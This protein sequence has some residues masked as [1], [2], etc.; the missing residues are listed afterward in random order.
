[1]KGEKQ[2]CIVENRSDLTSVTEDC[3]TFVVESALQEVPV[4]E[5]ERIFR[6]I[7][8]ADHS[9]VGNLPLYGVIRIHLALLF[10][11]TGTPPMALP[12]LI[13]LYR[14]IDEHLNQNG[15]DTI[16]C[17]GLSKNYQAVVVDVAEKHPVNVKKSA[18]SGGRR[19]VVGFIVGI[20]GYFRLIADQMFSFFWKHTC[21]NPDP[22]QTVF[23]P[24]V[25]RF[26]NIRPVLDKFSDEYE[27]VLP[28]SS[29]YWLRNRN[30]R[31]AAIKK[32]NPSPLDY[33]V[34]LGGIIDTIRR[35]KY[36]LGN[37]FAEHIP[38]LANT[39]VAKQ[40]IADL[41][42]ERLVVGSLGSRQQSILYA[43]IE[44]G[45][46][47]YHVP[48]SGTNGYEK[49]PPS[50]TVHF[51]P[52]HHIITHLEDSEQV[53]NTENIVPA[54][55]PKLSELSDRDI[56]PAD[57]WQPDAIRI[58]IATQPFPDPIRTRFI[59]QV[60]DSLK[61]TPNSIDVVVKIHPNETRTFYESVILEYP[62]RVRIVEKD[63]YEYVTGA[64]LTITINS[65][66]GLESMVVGTPCVCIGIWSPLIRAR[67]YAVCGPTPVLSTTDEIRTF[68]SGLT[69]ARVEEL[70]QSERTFANEMYLNGDIADRISDVILSNNQYPIKNLE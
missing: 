22:T 61:L 67:P 27:L 43:A 18:S 38:G 69:P 34:T 4:V 53:S 9:Q 8:E 49:T 46:D 12:H 40:M 70:A 31:Y 44:A 52:G 26:N 19:M 68:F 42:P 55:R 5:F 58:V 14:L 48:H 29:V 32:Y 66:V 21:R 24:H 57:D 51:V 64:E 7:I 56:K 10:D 62:F 15:Y 54:G 28:I 33:F 60:L 63:I 50:E 39:V 41:E 17:H 11:P 36:L 16:L 59:Q 45:I 25:N 13:I 2:L 1:M 35:G 20:Y 30:N 6:S 65:N 47:T 3:D 23:V 37:L